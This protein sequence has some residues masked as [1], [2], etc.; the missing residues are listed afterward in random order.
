MAVGAGP[1]APHVVRMRD[2]GWESQSATT[3]NRYSIVCC[4]PVPLLRY[5][6]TLIPLAQRGCVIA[7]WQRAA[8]GMSTARVWVGHTHLTVLK[9]FSS[10]AQPRRY[11]L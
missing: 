8:S 7:L 5:T 3:V 11:W 1:P 9:G 4:H 6:V 10:L 2:G